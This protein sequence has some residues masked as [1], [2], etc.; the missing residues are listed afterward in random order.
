MQMEDR[1]CSKQYAI[2]TMNPVLQH[3]SFGNKQ[4]QAIIK[5]TVSGYSFMGYG[6]L[7]R[8]QKVFDV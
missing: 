1:I 2:A 3:K 6:I 4:L 5:Y 8:K 7:R